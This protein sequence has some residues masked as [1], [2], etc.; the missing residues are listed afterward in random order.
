MIAFL[1]ILFGCSNRPPETITETIY[2][3]QYIPWEL[4]QIECG[5]APAGTTV[6][7]LAMSWQNNTGCLRAHQKVIEGL[8]KNY[9]EEGIQIYE[10]KE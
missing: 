5:E 3:K 8:I 4:L 1:M 7:S 10:R 2:E 9:T 6:R